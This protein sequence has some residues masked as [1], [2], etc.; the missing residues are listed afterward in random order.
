MLSTQC[1]DTEIAEPFSASS[2]FS[3]FLVRT[4]RAGSNASTVKCGPGAPRTMTCSG[5]GKT[6]NDHLRK[7]C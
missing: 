5:A 1:E 6:K 3:A 2:A 4:S 7:S